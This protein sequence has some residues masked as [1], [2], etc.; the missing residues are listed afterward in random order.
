MIK[1][2]DGGTMTGRAAITI[3]LALITISGTLAGCFAE[4]ESNKSDINADFTFSPSTNIQEK[5]TITFDA[6]PS[7]PS[8]GTLTYR[9]DFDGDGDSETTGRTATWSYTIAG[10]YNVTLTATDGNMEDKETKVLTVIGADAAVPSADPGTDWAEM[11]CDDEDGPNP[12]SKERYLIYICE[13][14][15]DSDREV[16]ATT[17]VFL[18]AGESTAGGEAYLTEYSWDLDATTDSDGDG[19]SEN[20]PDASGETFDWSNVAPGE[21]ELALTVTNSEGV[22]D[23]ETFKVF[24]NYVGIW[25]DFNQPAN[26]TNGPGETWFEYTV[27]Y[28]DETENTIV[29][30]EFWLT[31]PKEDGDWIAGS[32]DNKLDIYVFNETDEEVFNTSSYPQGEDDTAGLRSKGDCSEDNDCLQVSISRSNMREDRYQDG[33]WT[34]KIHNE[35][36][37]DTQVV[38]FRIL[39]TYKQIRQIKRY[40]EVHF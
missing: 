20:D 9:W 15:G 36:L 16:S 12:S 31:Y 6:S 23:S 1:A 27:I 30:A 32:G 14:K 24:V 17:T 33:D 34:V 13:D 25:K 18:D 28:D 38:E 11:D 21:Y 4:D 35:K 10:T 22:S 2:L 5:E 3:L 29:R 7:V 8:D 39:L 19:D 37:H 26:T 40:L